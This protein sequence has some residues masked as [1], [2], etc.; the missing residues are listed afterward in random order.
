M[1]DSDPV[2][3]RHQCDD[4]CAA[5][6]YQANFTFIQKHDAAHRSFQDQLRLPLSRHLIDTHHRPATVAYADCATGLRKDD[7]AL[8]R[9][10]AGHRPIADSLPALLLQRLDPLPHSLFEHL[11]HL[12]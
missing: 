9:L 6:L 1:F 7:D 4:A 8:Q 3:S 12:P 11:I 5:I 2:L 10:L